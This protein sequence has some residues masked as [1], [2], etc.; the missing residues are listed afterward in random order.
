MS[1]TKPAAFS[2]YEVRVR[3]YRIWERA[4]RPEGCAELHWR[5]ALAELETERQAK[6]AG[7]VPPQPD[8]SHLP[9]RSAAK[10]I[11]KSEDEAA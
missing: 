4:G 2:D 6:E 7:E 8:V 9:L 11:S 1:K 10:A 5:E 3:A